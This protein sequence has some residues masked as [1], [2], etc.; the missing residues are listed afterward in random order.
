M[1][2][3]SNPVVAGNYVVDLD[4]ARSRCQGGVQAT[5]TK[6]VVRYDFLNQS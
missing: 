2:S 6:E 5:L 1:L 3:R 4:R